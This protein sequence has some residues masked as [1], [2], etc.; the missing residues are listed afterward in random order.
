MRF[1]DL[2]RSLAHIFTGQ[3]LFDRNA[4][5]LHLNDGEIKMNKRFTIAFS[6]L[7]IFGL[8]IVAFAYTKANNTNHAS[9]ASCP[10]MEKKTT[11]VAETSA[12]KDSCGMADCCKDGKCSMGGACCK[13]GD[14]CPM[15]DTK[16][17]SASAD[18]SKITFSDAGA[19]D[20]CCATGASCCAGG[21]SACCKGKHS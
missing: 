8:A 17:A 15:K 13:S 19:K 7:L 16:S 5:L 3:N 2:E 12:E 11:A 18:Y 10:M 6:A 14:S 1:S 9:A 4:K 20:D 21:A